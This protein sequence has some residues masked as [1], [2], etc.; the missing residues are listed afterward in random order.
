MFGF[1]EVFA[2]LGLALDNSTPNLRLQ[3]LYNNWCQRWAV[4]GP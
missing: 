4:T 2:M 1:I 3:T